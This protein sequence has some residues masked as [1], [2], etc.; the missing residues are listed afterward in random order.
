MDTATSTPNKS[1]N[2]RQ[3]PKSQSVRSSAK[4]KPKKSTTQLDETPGLRD[5]PISP[6]TPPRS[7][8]SAG[9]SSLDGNVSPVPTAKNP[10]RGRKKTIQSDNNAI[11]SPLPGK[12][13]SP[14]ATQISNLNTPIK[15]T[16]MY[17]GPTF[18]ASPAPSS[19][20]IPKFFSKSLPSLDKVPDMSIT[21]AE[22]ASEES[23]NCT[24]D[25]SPTI[26]PRKEEQQVREPS[27]LDVF[28]NADR[29]EK[30][31]R[32]QGGLEVS[33][34]NENR[35]QSQSS[36]PDSSKSHSRHPTGR[37]IFPME[38]EISNR[39]KLDDAK[40]TESSPSIM[41]TNYPNS[42]AH[43]KAKTQ[44]LKDLLMNPKPQRPTSIS[45]TTSNALG[46]SPFMTPIY[47]G[48]DGRRASGSNTPLS[49]YDK[50]SSPA[51][52]QSPGYSSPYSNSASSRPSQYPNSS[53][54]RQE[55]LEYTST[56]L[57][58]APS[59][60]TP[61]K[62]YYANDSTHFTNGGLNHSYGPNSPLS[63]RNKKF[64]PEDAL[65]VTLGNNNN[66]ASMNLI[67]DE[68]R[69]ILKIDSLGTSSVRS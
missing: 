26:Q 49:V 28:F 35:A 32:T 18:H 43:A 15:Q 42:E 22:D 4:R 2:R 47:S 31:L 51:R 46:S 44:A 61:S 25:S 7:T 56:E 52:I 17:A 40:R 9:I 23:S 1:Q 58:E 16:Q 20:P 54:L 62:G 55:I 12:E 41:T 27:P 8:R 13:R 10:R 19:L 3:G 57:P 67:E 24:A 64:Q 68:I 65:K 48:N 33:P 37:S 21:A 50:T 6:L 34:T 63:H 60:P 66:N 59:T 30:A 5:D 14:R 53:H 36:A 69:K 29:K 11:G 38:L 39:P 45:S